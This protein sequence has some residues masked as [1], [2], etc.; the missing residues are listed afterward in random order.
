MENKIN[1]MMET[2]AVADE[3]MTGGSA[4]EALLTIA[5]RA[6]KGE[7]EVEGANIEE[8]TIL[9]FLASQGL[10]AKGIVELCEETARTIIDSGFEQTDSM[11][12]IVEGM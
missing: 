3:G 11:S 12:V 6:G 4:V 9:A 5:E 2:L 10:T 8:R 7:V 1:K